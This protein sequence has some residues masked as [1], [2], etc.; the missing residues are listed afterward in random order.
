MLPPRAAHPA[1]IRSSAPACTS[2]TDL[3]ILTDALWQ[4]NSP[5][6]PENSAAFWKGEFKNSLFRFLYFKT[7]SQTDAER[8]FKSFLA[9][10]ELV[11]SVFARFLRA[12]LPSFEP[13]GQCLT[14]S[15]GANVKAERCLGRFQ[16][17]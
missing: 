7:G 14:R 12:S 4:R 8:L 15:L 17:T 16:Q 13:G 3:A 9:R 11:A 10:N 6:T 2:L 1:K 5:A